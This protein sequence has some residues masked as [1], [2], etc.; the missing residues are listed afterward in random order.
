MFI[1][2]DPVMPTGNAQTF[3]L[4]LSSEP[5]TQAKSELGFVTLTNKSLNIPLNIKK[6]LWTSVRLLVYMLYNNIRRQCKKKC[7]QMSTDNTRKIAT[8]WYTM[9]HSLEPESTCRAAGIVSV[10]SIWKEGRTM[11]HL[12]RNLKRTF[13]YSFISQRRDSTDVDSQFI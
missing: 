8:L 7:Q 9:T 11:A 6:F 4:S 13:L 2:S 12:H 5:T 10:F 1:D 3:Q